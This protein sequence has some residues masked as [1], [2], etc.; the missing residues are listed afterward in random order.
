MAAMK[1]RTPTRPTYMVPIRSS[2][3]KVD[4]SAVMPVDRPTVAKA[5]TTSKIM[6]RKVNPGSKMAISRVTPKTSPPEPTTTLM[7]LRM[8]WE[9]ISRW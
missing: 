1:R 7:A 6:D 2:W 8:R 5:E 4:R 3:E 9:G